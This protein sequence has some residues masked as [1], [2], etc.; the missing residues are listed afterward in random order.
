MESCGDHVLRASVE[1]LIDRLR[2]R[3]PAIV[4]FG[5]NHHIDLIRCW[6]RVLAFLRYE[7]H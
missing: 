6:P 7:M 3:D 4:P 5:G 2:K 1:K